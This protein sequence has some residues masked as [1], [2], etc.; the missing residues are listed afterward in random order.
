MSLYLELD[1][2]GSETVEGIA[3]AVGW[4]KNSKK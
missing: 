2:F 1:N 3:L 4:G